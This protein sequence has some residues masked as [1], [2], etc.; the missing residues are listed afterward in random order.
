MNLQIEREDIDHIGHTCHSEKGYLAILCLYETC[1]I[2]YF[3][4]KNILKCFGEDYKIVAENCEGL[5]ESLRYI[6]N[7]PFSIY[8]RTNFKEK[9]ESR[10]EFDDGFQIGDWGVSCMGKTLKVDNDGIK[11]AAREDEDLEKVIFN[12]EKKTVSVI[13]KNPTLSE[14]ALRIVDLSDA[15]EFLKNYVKTLKC[16]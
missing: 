2:E 12:V 13:V 9:E 1:D 10:I 14:K 3:L 5:E 4:L 6:T 7:L 11:L 8:L 16:F 15:V